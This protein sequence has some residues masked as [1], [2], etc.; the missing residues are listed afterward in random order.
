[1]RNRAMLKARM[2]KLAEQLYFDPLESEETKLMY[3]PTQLW[4]WASVKAKGI[5][6]MKSA[7][8]AAYTAMKNGCPGWI[9]L[10]VQRYASL[11]TQAQ[12]ATSCANLGAYF[13][14]FSAGVA[15]FVG[16]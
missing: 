8:S 16:G 12:I 9:D 10:L 2:T 1:M 13:T 4:T 5:A 7:A 14:P 15:S 3:T 6:L 11:G